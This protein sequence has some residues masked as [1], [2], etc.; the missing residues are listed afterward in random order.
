[1]RLTTSEQLN[2]VSRFLR[3]V[4]IVVE[5]REEGTGKQPENGKEMDDVDG[6]G[7]KEEERLAAGEFETER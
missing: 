1:M 2:H 4:L 7:S 6:S 3:A 5:V